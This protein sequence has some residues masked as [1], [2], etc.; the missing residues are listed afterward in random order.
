MRIRLCA[1]EFIQLLN[2]CCAL[3]APLSQT[4]PAKLPLGR[5]WLKSLTNS[6]ALMSTYSSMLSRS[7][8]VR[9]AWPSATRASLTISRNAYCSWAVPMSASVAPVK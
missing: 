6:F 1:G 4:S 9:G 7:P 2:D 8:Q 3:V 5:L